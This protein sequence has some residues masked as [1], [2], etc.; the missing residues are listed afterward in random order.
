VRWLTSAGCGAGNLRASVRA[1]KLE[2]V[3]YWL[4]EQT[5]KEEARRDDA[6]RPE[7]DAR[8]DLGRQKLIST[9]L[10]G[11]SA[12]EGAAEATCANNKGFAPGQPF[13]SDAETWLA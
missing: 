10:E 2:P 12:R 4:D 11:Q 9:D 5:V 7:N 13:A 6:S 8:A 3:E 1:V